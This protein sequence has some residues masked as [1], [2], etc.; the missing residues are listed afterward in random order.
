MP[1]L[2][3]NRRKYR[4]DMFCTF[5]RTDKSGKV[6]TVRDRRLQIIAQAGAPVAAWRLALS[7]RQ[8]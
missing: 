7:R 3:S 5:S 4:R 2:R 1:T 8:R 6:A